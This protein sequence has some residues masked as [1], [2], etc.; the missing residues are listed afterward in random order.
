MPLEPSAKS[1]LIWEAKEEGNFFHRA[2]A[3]TE[4]ADG[5]EQSVAVNPLGGVAS[6]SLFHTNGEPLGGDVHLCG[7]LVESMLLTEVLFHQTQELLGEHL[8]SGGYAL[9]LGAV[10]VGTETKEP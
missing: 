5:F 3:A 6:R 8:R 2:F 4:Q 7:V 1:G 9:T 10:Q